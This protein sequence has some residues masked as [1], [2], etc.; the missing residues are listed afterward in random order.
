[1]FALLVLGSFLALIVCTVM[2]LVNL[3]RK[4]K[5]NKPLIGLGV[6][7]AVLAVSFIATP[8]S[9]S[10]SSSNASSVAS[11][12]ESKAVSTA[13]SVET[14]QSDEV[15]ISE[16]VLVEQDGI[17]IT[18]KS[19]TPDAADTSGIVWLANGVIPGADG[20]N[21]LIENDSDKNIQ[22]YCNGL[23]VND[24]MID[25]TFMPDV[26]ISKKANETLYIPHSGLADSGIYETQKIE[27]WFTVYDKDAQK[28][29]FNADDVTIET[30][31]ANNEPTP[32]PDF[33]E[34]VYSENGITITGTPI[35]E[36][37]PLGTNI[38][39]MLIKNDSGKD[40][41]AYCD[42]IS[43]NGYMVNP[44]VLSKKIYS[45]KKA[46][47]TIGAQDEELAKNSIDNVNDIECTVKLLDPDTLMPRWTASNIEFKK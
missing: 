37:M 16:Q 34:P 8:T 29:L 25:T 30:S 10:S 4:K 27:V 17:K 18:A 46:V 32:D 21:L 44:W 13:S 28:A 39:T 35:Q 45:G 9:S 5:N 2:C 43:A 24:F 38:V 19:Y 6:A 47:C 41:Q 7:F 23:A 3:I 40:V 11:K 14:K 31:A 36:S 22:V 42:T 26:S 12:A 1:M 20:L 33:S 15:S